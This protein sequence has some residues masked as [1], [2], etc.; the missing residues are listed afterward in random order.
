MKKKIELTTQKIGINNT[1]LTPARHAQA[2]DKRVLLQ[3]KLSTRVQE[4]TFGDY[5]K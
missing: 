5:H 1:Q 2:Q 4:K 3:T